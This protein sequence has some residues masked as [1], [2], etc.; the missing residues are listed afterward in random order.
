MTKRIMEEILNRCWVLMLLK[1]IIAERYKF[2]S[3]W[4]IKFA[5]IQIQ[6]K[7]VRCRIRLERL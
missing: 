6:K 5:G 2:K 3:I 7:W 1:C 4:V